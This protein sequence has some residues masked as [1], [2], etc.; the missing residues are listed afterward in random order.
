L[1][2]YPLINVYQ[3]G[4]GFEELEEEEDEGAIDEDR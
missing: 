3:A 2:L 4:E 1:P